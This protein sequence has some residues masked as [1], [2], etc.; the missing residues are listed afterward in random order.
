M[1]WFRLSSPLTILALALTLGLVVN[2]PVQVQ[3]QSRSP[4]FGRQLPNQGNEYSYSSLRTDTTALMDPAGGFRAPRGLGTPDNRIGGGTRGK[5]CNEDEQA[6]IPLIPTSGIGTTAAEYPTFL[7]YMPQTSAA[8]LEFIL[9]DVQGK[10]LY[11]TKYTLAKSADSLKSAPRIMSLTLPVSAN[12]SPL[13][14]GAEYNWELTLICNSSS[15]IG[16][17]IVDERT[18]DIVV[19]GKIKRVALDPT[20]AQRLQ[21]ASPQERFA[22]YA[23][24]GLWYERLTTLVELQRDR[25]N[26]ENLSAAW[27]KLLTSAGL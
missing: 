7:W 13:K 9:R 21:K 11:R 19:V 8:E 14:I 25:P 27:D 1:V 24:A 10:E 2:L 23:N 6:P 22:L 15:Q 5:G 20:M 12:F 16:N 3:A 17:V 26:D 4:S 18:G